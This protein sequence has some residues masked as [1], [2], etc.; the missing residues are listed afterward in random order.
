V[1]RVGDET[2]VGDGFDERVGGEEVGDSESG[3]TVLE[4][5][6]SESLDTSESKVAVEG[7]GDGSAVGFRK[8]RETRR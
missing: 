4:S 7:G 8:G 1:G 2:G 6:E 3:E 5:S